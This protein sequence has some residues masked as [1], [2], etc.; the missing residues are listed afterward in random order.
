MVQLKMAQKEAQMI[1]MG[2]FIF[3]SEKIYVILSTGLTGL[4]YTSAE[5]KTINIVF[6]VIISRLE[7]STVYKE[8]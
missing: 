2:K 6:L 7:N 8:Y 3:N 5:I 1:Q 4:F